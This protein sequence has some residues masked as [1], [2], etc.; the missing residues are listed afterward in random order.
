MALEPDPSQGE[1]NGK[2]LVFLA[3]SLLTQQR[4]VYYKATLYTNNLKMCTGIYHRGYPDKYI[5]V[6]K[7]L[8]QNSPMYMKG[9][10]V[11]LL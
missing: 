9:K 1:A 11:S 3:A 8:E 4:G 6:R 10:I 7:V 2:S 5:R